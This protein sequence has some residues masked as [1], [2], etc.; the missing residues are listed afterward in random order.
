MRKRRLGKSELQLTTIGLGTWAIGGGD[1]KFGW[2]PQDEREAI[3]AVLQAV[4][5]G[6]NWIDTAAVY[7]DGQSEILVGR[8]LK[9]LGVLP[10]PLVATKWSRVV[11]P[12]GN[13]IGDLSRANLMREVEESLRRLDI[14][15]IDLYQVH[16][17]KPPED[18]EEAWGAMAE[19][20]EQGKVRHIGVSNFNVEQMKRIQRIHPIASL[21]PPYS[22]I[23]RGVED[24]ILE[25]C[26]EADI[27][28]ICYS[29]MYKGLLTG[30]F[31]S[32]RISQLGKGD[33]R[34]NDPNFQSPKF[35]QH[36][37]L[38]EG[39][40]P[41]AERNNRTLAELSIAW[42]LRRPMVTS[43]IVG[44]RRPD[45]ILATAGAGDWDLSDADI[46]E[47]DALLA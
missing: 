34:L 26:A 41:I 16:W 15:T 21:Q 22:M 10:R 29:P 8:A 45:Q 24:E 25:F 30:A 14:E 33:H 2:G 37:A 20:V 27:G 40:R 46:A 43:A 18:I 4:E 11:Q 42:V 36:L 9:E 5:S 12:D 47:I 38:V 13:V 6:I 17:P 39:L 1:W 28:V 32:S 35:E 44:A 31:D 7:G 19:L 3:A 23:M